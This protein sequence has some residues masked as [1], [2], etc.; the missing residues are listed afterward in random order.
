[1]NITG[2]E[3]KLKEAFKGIATAPSAAEAP[4][5]VR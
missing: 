5:E 3:V 2:V 4:R 1:M